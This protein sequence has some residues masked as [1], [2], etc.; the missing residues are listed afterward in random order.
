MKFK[1]FTPS[2][3]IT[4]SIL[5]RIVL[6]S[7]FVFSV[8]NTFAAEE[9]T[10]FDSA[11]NHIILNE[12]PYDASKAKHL[13]DSLLKNSVNEKEKMRSLMLLASICIQF[14]DHEDAMIYA[15]RAEKIAKEKKDYEWQVRTAGFLSA[16]FRDAN[17][18]AE[19][20]EHLKVVERASK[21]MKKSSDYDLIQINIHHEKAHFEWRDGHYETAIR[22]LEQ[23]QKHI[24][25]L[26]EVW[27]EGLYSSNYLML[28]ENYLEL[29]EY[30]KSAKYF[31]LILENK[32][33]NENLNYAAVYRGLG[34]IEMHN[35]NYDQ[36]LDYLKKAE[37][38]LSSNQHFSISSP[39]YKSLSNYYRE[40]DMPLQA[41]HY[42]SLHL[43]AV[44]SR[45]SF[46]ERLSDRLV[47]RRLVEKRVTQKRNA[48]LI[49]AL[50]ALA[51]LVIFLTVRLR[52]VRKKERRRYEAFV[53]KV[54][55]KPP[56]L[57]ANGNLPSTKE[58]VANGNRSLVNKTVE[59]GDNSIMPKETEERLLKELEK[60]ET[61]EFFLNKELSLPSLATVLQTNTKYLSYIINTHKGK[62][63]SNYIH[64][65]RI[66]F[67]VDKLQNDP[68]YLNYK[69][70]FLAEEC[71]YSSHSKFASVF[72]SIVG[73]S[74]SAFVSHVKKEKSS[75]V[76]D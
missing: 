32:V 17:L 55:K 70:A 42:D 9:L 46:T 7:I 62:D 40:V 4:H 66:G 71:G 22:E 38:F 60:L 76:S 5:K 16:I 27:R 8:S 35:R 53:Q 3:Q 57:E 41:M 51:V 61:S 15:L 44:K 45:A 64:G 31:H 58:P 34:D 68:R 54:R 11:F 19:A 56:I 12:I 30:E 13:A 69:I 25:R 18:F 48:V 20:R 28:G 43:E 6:I 72:K 29:K 59:N 49:G 1:S 14:N 74:P 37:E 2:I 39:V 21:R 24:S 63:F 47:Q 23:A 10:P 67:A 33:P 50:G 36:A 52:M 75:A 65:L 26:K 73:L